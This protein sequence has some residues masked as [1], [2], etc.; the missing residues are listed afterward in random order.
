MTEITVVKIRTD[1]PLPTPRSVISSPIHMMTVVPATMVITMVA[2]VKVEPLGMSGLLVPE[3][4]QPL[5]R[6]PD[7]ASS[8]YPVDWSKARPTVRYLVY[9]VILDCP[10]C[11]SCFSVSSRGITTVSS[12]R[13]ML[14]VMYGMMPSANTDKRSSAWPLSRLT[15]A[16]T[17]AVELPAAVAA[18]EQ[19]AT[20]FSAIPGVG[21]EAP[22]RNSAIRASV[23]SIFL[24]R[25]GVW[26]AR[27]KAVS[28][29]S[30]RFGWSGSPRILPGTPSFRFLALGAQLARSAKLGDRTAGLFDLLDGGGR[31]RVRGHAERDR[32]LTGAQH[33]DQLAGPG[34]APGH[35]VLRGHVAALR[36]QLG[37]PAGVHHL[38]GGAEPGV[39]EALQLRHPAVQRHLAA[40]EAEGN[41]GARLGALGAAARGLPLGRLAAAD[42]RLGLVR[43]RRRPQVMQLEPA[44]GRRFLRQLESGLRGRLFDV[45]HCRQSTSSTVTRWRTVLIMPRNSGRSGLTTTWPIRRSPSDRSEFRCA[46]VPPIFDLTCVTFSCAICPLS[47]GRAR[48]RASPQHGRGRHVLDRQAALGRDLLGPIQ[49]LQGRDRRVHDVDRVRRAQRAGQHVVDPGALEHGP[50]RAA[51]DDAGTRAGRL[52]QHHARRFLALDRVRDRAADP[53]HPEEVLL[54]LFDALGDGGRDFLGLA[55][56]DADHPVAVTHHHEGGEAE[57]AA[58]LD[59]LGHAVDGHHVLNVGSLLFGRAATPV[60]TALAPLAAAASSAPWSSWWH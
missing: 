48:G 55:V 38:V 39:G 36:V 10:A 17:P 53:R 50:D 2:M 3:A 23:T 44:P 27:T 28:M 26:N 1:M 13:M 34:R 49:A 47:L 15:M 24:R 51:G 43:T 22:N 4:P 16:S 42:P 46:L 40:L 9:W 6:V 5:N 37:Q 30:P 57:P 52:E 59:H 18:F 32:E 31:E 45:G 25:S 60:L 54:G 41:L 29:R 20:F 35:H 58:A 19:K 12:C 56:P 33:L 21:S 14:A 8:T 11:P 7:L